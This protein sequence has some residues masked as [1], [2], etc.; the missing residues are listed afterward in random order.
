MNLTS[1]E[2]TSK[3]K[4]YAAHLL[5]VGPI[6]VFGLLTYVMLVHGRTGHVPALTPL[7]TWVGTFAVPA[8]FAFWIWMLRDHFR[9]PRYARTPGWSVALIFLNWGA[10]FAY[11]LWV[12]RSSHVPHA[13]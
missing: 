11:F 9:V 6:A 3:G 4:W 12:W 1:S 2:T 7:I 5:A 8:T 10:A 13:A